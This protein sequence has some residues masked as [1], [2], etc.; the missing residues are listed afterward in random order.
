MPNISECVLIGPKT[1]LKTIFTDCIWSMEEGNAFTGFCHSVYGG[2]GKSAL[3]GR[4]NLPWEVWGSTL[5]GDSVWKGVCVWG[6]AWRG[7]AWGG[8]CVERG[9]YTGG[10]CVE[11]SPSPR[12]GERTAGTYPTG[13]RAC[14]EYTYYKKSEFNELPV[15]CNIQ[16]YF[17]PV[18]ILYHSM[19]FYIS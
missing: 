9:P 11:G 2:G 1:R 12:Y 16:R 15:G 3:G 18:E 6:S 14:L 5:G 19:L 10:V 13:M 4:G 8:V 7:S 17:V